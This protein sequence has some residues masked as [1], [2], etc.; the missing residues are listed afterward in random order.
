MKCKTIIENREEARIKDT[1]VL[2]AENDKDYQ[3]CRRVAKQINKRKKK[4]YR[5]KK[6]QYLEDKYKRKQVKEF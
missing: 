4:M 5:D 1:S 3:R 6:I 2:T